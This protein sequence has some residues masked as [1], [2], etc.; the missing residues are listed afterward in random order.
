MRTID[1]WAGRQAA[2]A[3]LDSVRLLPVICLLLPIRWR[4]ENPQQAA[5]PS[6]G[7]NSPRGIRSSKFSPSHETHSGAVLLRWRNDTPD[8]PGNSRP[9]DAIVSTEAGADAR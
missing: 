2:R 8:E 3:T 4:R 7:Q 9:V 6:H 1:E 5:W